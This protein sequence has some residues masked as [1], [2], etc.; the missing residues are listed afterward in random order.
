MDLGSIQWTLPW[1]G[2]LQ[3]RAPSVDREVPRGSLRLRPR[4]PRVDGL[5]APPGGCHAANGQEAL[6]HRVHG[7]AKGTAL[8][9]NDV[10]LGQAREALVENSRRRGALTASTE[11]FTGTQVESSCSKD[12]KAL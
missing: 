2:A 12:Q 7:R 4:E 1:Q 3:H 8:R 11:F 9:L 6:D 5:D 10:P